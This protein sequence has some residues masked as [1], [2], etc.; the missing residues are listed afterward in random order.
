MLAAA[1]AWN[2][3]AEAEMGQLSFGRYIAEP[4]ISL[5]VSA[6]S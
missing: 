3:F 2:R 4:A 6:T 1:L 5:K